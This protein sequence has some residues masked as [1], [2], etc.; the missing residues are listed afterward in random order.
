MFGGEACRQREHD[1]RDVSVDRLHMPSAL[2]RL[3][4]SPI[5]RQQLTES[6]DRVSIDHALEHI[7]QV[8]VG[9]DA[10][11][12][13]RFNQRAECRPPLSTK[14]RTREEMILSSE[15]NRTD[16]ALNRIGI[17]LD[18]A[19]AQELRKIMLVA[20]LCRR[21]TA[22][23]LTPGRSASITIASFSASVK[24]RRFEPPSLAGSAAAGIVKTFSPS[25]SLAA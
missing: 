22:A 4:R 20:M 19:V 5:P 1:Q 25:E 14:I 9:L 3:R 21:Q 8:C 24:L 2:D 12:L 18:A 15:S 10:V 16:C 11:H 7:A 23:A 13:A 6:I 17:K